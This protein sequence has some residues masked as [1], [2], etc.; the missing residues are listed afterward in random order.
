VDFCRKFVSNCKELH[1][2]DNMK[3]VAFWPEASLNTKSSEWDEDIRTAAAH[4]SAPFHVS[5]LGKRWKPT[6]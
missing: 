6:L 4:K 1:A 3:W 5:R 2:M